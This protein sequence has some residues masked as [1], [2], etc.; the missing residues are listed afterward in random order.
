M[1][2]WWKD[3]LRPKTRDQAK[4]AL[5]RRTLRFENLEDRRMLTTA[6]TPVQPLFIQ[7]GPS[8]I[9]NPA[10]T[11][12]NGIPKST[13][14][15]V[16]TVA[17]D[18]VLQSSGN[19]VFAGTVNGGIWETTTY[20]STSNGPTWTDITDQDD[21]ITTTSGTA[22][23][24]TA[25]ATSGLNGSDSISAMIVDSSQTLP[26]GLTAGSALVAATGNYS[27]VGLNGTGPA[28][29]SLT[30]VWEDLSVSASTINSNPTWYEVAGIPT[31]K[32]YAAVAAGTDSTL[33]G[34]ATE[35]I[36]A[37]NNGGAQYFTPLTLVT[38]TVGGLYE[39]T[40]TYA[41]GVPT[42]TAFTPSTPLPAGAVTDV[43]E[44]PSTPSTYYAAVIG[45]NAGI[46]RSMTN[47]NVNGQAVN[48]G[49]DGNTWVQIASIA[50]MP[51]LSG[52]LNIQIAAGKNNT[53]YI[54]IVGADDQLSAV[55]MTTNDTSNLSSTQAINQGVNW[56][57][58]GI[59][60]TADGGINPYQLGALNFAITVNPNNSS[61]IYV[62]GDY[63][64]P[65][66]TTGTW[67]NSI[68]SAE[69]TGT[70]F[71]AAVTG[72]TATWTPIVGSDAGNTSPPGGTRT[73]EVLPNG[74]L[75]EGS[76]GG[77]Y[78]RTSP[79]STGGTWVSHN[80]L[81]PTTAST[82]SNGLSAEEFYSVA[83]NPLSD[84]I[85]GGT[86]DLGVVEQTATGADQWNT[87]SVNDPNESVTPTTNVTT[88]SPIGISGGQL[89]VAD[90]PGSSNAVLYGSNDYFNDFFVQNL[91]SNMTTP[92]ALTTPAMTVLGSNN[93]TIYQVEDN[94]GTGPTF[95][96]QTPIV[97]NADQQAG[98]QWLVVG[99]DYVYE[100][101][102]GG[103]TWT[104]IDGLT[105]NGSS[106]SPSSG[107]GPVTTMA[108][109]GVYQGQQ[110]PYVLWAGSSGSYG[111][112]LRV[113]ETEVTGQGTYADPYNQLIPQTAYPGG[114][115]VGIV[116][117]PTNFTNTFVADNTN[118]YLATVSFNGQTGSAAATTAATKFTSL[119]GPGGGFKISGI[120]YVPDPYQSYDLLVVSGWNAGSATNT[121]VYELEIDKTTGLP[122]SGASWS[123]V[124]APASGVQTG[125]TGQEVQLPHV[126]VTAITYNSGNDTLVLTTE[127]RGA[128]TLPAFAESNTG[129]TMSITGS[130]TT[131]DVSLVQSTTQPG[132]FY[133]LVSTGGA[134]TPDTLTINGKTASWPI[135][136]ALIQQSN[137]QTTATNNNLD[138]DFNQTYAAGVLTPATTPVNPIPTGR[139][140]DDSSG[141]TNTVSVEDD[142]GTIAISGSAGGGSLSMGNSPTTITLTS[143]LTGATLIGGSTTNTTFTF[144]NWSVPA[145]VNGA[146]GSDTLSYTSNNTNAVAF[147]LTG[148]AV[149]GAG[150]LTQSVGGTLQAATLTL[151]SIT[152]ADITG[153]T[154]NNTFT[155]GGW[156]GA[157][158]LVGGTGS[159]ST[160]NSLTDATA[161]EGAYIYYSNIYISVGTPANSTYYNPAIALSN[162]QTANLT[163]SAADVYFFDQGWSGTSNV[164][165]G[166]GLS[167]GLLIRPNTNNTTFT[168][169]DS[170]ISTVGTS[171]VT[172]TVN[173][174]GNIQYY[175]M[176]GSG[177]AN[178]YNVSNFNLLSNIVAGGTTN[179]VLA[180]ESQ[181]FIVSNTSMTVGSNATDGDFVFKGFTAAN[182]GLNIDTITGL[183][184][185]TINSFSGSGTLSAGKGAD[186]FI[187]GTSGGGDLDNL[188][189]FSIAGGGGSTLTLND[190]AA[191]TSS[192][193]FWYDMG[194]TPGTPSVEPDPEEPTARTWGG[195]TFDNN[196]YKVVLV[197]ATVEATKFL[198][199][200]SASIHYVVY[201]NATYPNNF[202]GV[203]FYDASG[204]QQTINPGPY[205]TG[206]WTFS[207]AQ[208][209][210][211]S[212][213]DTF[214]GVTPLVMTGG[215]SSSTS[216]SPL[217]RVYDAST[218]DYQDE[219]YAYPTSYTG[220]VQAAVG[221][222]NP[223]DPN[224]YYIV[225]APGPGIAGEV[226]VW[227]TTGTLVTSF[228]PFGTSYT[229]GFNVAIGNVVAG[230][231]VPDIILGEQSQGTEVIVYDGTPL[232]TGAANPVMTPGRRW[233]A[234]PSNYTGGV[235]VAAAVFNGNNYA[236]VI[237]VPYTAGAAQVKVFDGYSIINNPTISVIDSYYALP[238][239]YTL[240]AT[241]AAGDV[242]GDGVPDIVVAAGINGNSEINVANGASVETGTA[243]PSSITTFYAYPTP[244]A[245]T[246]SYTA[247]AEAPVH[248]TLK[249]VL[250]DGRDEIF[251]SQ[252]TGGTPNGGVNLVWGY[253]GKLLATLAVS[254]SSGG[255]NLG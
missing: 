247:T 45:A 129:Y 180:D 217:V 249:D 154:G 214:N 49:Q 76:N 204:Q 18:T 218:G 64:P 46:Y 254:S 250:G 237:T 94:L 111:L 119:S 20:T 35:Y 155:I 57:S 138:F 69:D 166:T 80:G 61:Q 113:G 83:Y 124:G 74:E 125:I 73:L 213:I 114:A 231:T 54:G 48:N 225:T 230:S 189:A 41:N 21:I 90:D 181:N 14:G 200:P 158:S 177:G 229:G 157:G 104:A 37:A 224:S 25:T 159:T 121:G 87:I 208:P 164:T 233:E 62:G 197:G 169:T 72:T 241:V 246:F 100:S 115:P 84:S 191:G 238:Q 109:G 110:D 34:T 203:L 117:N 107:V 131:E 172:S 178:V 152:T 195:V 38:N 32:N 210:S 10:A 245:T 251:T 71:A 99:S 40:M 234:Y 148:G 167:N 44:D 132:Y 97:A 15:A 8:P 108:Y 52:A 252:G 89:A 24:T 139:F 221:Q 187:L 140:V 28:G 101:F 141:T 173:I 175:S 75:L 88:V 161:D 78:D 242:N 27:D 5:T 232:S 11:S 151:N 205:Q 182:S 7:S 193:S 168:M 135:N 23:G 13:I 29:G 202:L 1:R 146:G 226:E 55:Y 190:A 79:T 77:L 184:T 199:G 220:G 60:S 2:K 235:S 211:F 165:G 179:T 227:T 42:Y 130:G 171:N 66:S 85:I 95:E 170:A 207:N 149:N 196:V 243:N 65:S 248:I 103:A 255:L 67:P 102:N 33:S 176:F 228:Y 91:S 215:T 9:T 186:T 216:S 47:N 236:D 240:G 6:L 192:S 253:S 120:T 122:I 43:V 188:G 123:M 59:P 127:G 93:E 50:D 194:L 126:P 70:V 201:G 96:F 147:V 36:M 160:A 185:V 39:S 212:G 133:V 223:S 144:T 63:A 163:T 137:V 118:V 153:G 156:T 56:A 92:P 81:I 183:H 136:E 219:F 68:G 82:P 31:G 16:Q 145:T 142:T 209:I 134:Y 174:L 4:R 150:A 105:T 3:V 98:N 112:Y 222:F 239:A 12:T 128:W 143:A 53:L 198:V 206:Y 26:G 22:A 106:S 86:Q 19:L 162:F 17:V 30:G 244:G 116:M 58:L 51:E